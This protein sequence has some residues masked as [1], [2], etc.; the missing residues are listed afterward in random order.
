[1]KIYGQSLVN[2]ISRNELST[3]CAQIGMCYKDE[4]VSF[5][6]IDGGM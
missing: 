3:A 5:V 4:Y 1:M 2:L 6:R